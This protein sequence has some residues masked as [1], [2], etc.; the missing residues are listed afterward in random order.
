[1]FPAIRSPAG[2]CFRKMPGCGFSVRIRGRLRKKSLRII[3]RYDYDAYNRFEY[4]FFDDLYSY[5]GTKDRARLS[6]LGYAIGATISAS[7]SWARPGPCI[8]LMAQQGF[9]FTESVRPSL[10]YINGKVYGFLDTRTV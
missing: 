9:P 3:A 8:I 4:E 5:S 6:S 10:V 1:M 7:H 2:Y